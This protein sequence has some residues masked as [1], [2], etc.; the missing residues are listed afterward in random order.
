MLTKFE[1]VLTSI[2]PLP[3]LCTFIVKYLFKV[4]SQRNVV[5]RWNFQAVI[6]ILVK[7]HLRLHFRPCPTTDII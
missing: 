2:P 7:C 3:T 5:K 4:Q 1:R 6:S